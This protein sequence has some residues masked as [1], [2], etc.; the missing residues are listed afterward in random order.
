VAVKSQF[1]KFNLKY[2]TEYFFSSTFE[3]IVYISKTEN[4]NIISEKIGE[5][6]PED[7]KSLDSRYKALNKEEQFY[8]DRV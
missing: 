4:S 1:K 8:S 3:A 5:S 2:S 6:E 7:D